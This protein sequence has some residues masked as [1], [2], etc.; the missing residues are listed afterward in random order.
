MKRWMCVDFQRINAL[1][2]EKITIEKKNKGN[3]SL[4]PKPKINEMYAKLKGVKYFTIL[5]LRR[6]YYHITLTPEAR[7]KTAF[8]TPFGK[9]EFNKV[10]LH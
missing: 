2:L 7:A 5:D 6:G 10:H 4:Q 1:Q 3:L 8:V 9:Y